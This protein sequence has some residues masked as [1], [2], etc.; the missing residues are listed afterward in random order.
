MS[1]TIDEAVPTADEYP[2]ETGR[3]GAT[4]LLPQTLSG[5]RI[6][7]T[8][9]RRSDELSSAVERRGADVMHAPALRI[10]P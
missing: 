8:S 7:V 4:P 5:F 1:K 6:G 10:A 2:E 9:D 3:T